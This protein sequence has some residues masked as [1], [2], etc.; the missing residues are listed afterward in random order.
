MVDT[1][2]R[3]TFVAATAEMDHAHAVKAIENLVGHEIS[4]GAAR[5]LIQ[6][7]NTRGMLGG[8]S[9]SGRLRTGSLLLPSVPVDVVV[10]PWSAVR[11][12]IGIG[13]L[14][15]YGRPRLAP[16]TE[17]LPGRVAARGSPDRGDHRDSCR[18]DAGPAGRGLEVFS[19][20]LPGVDTQFADRL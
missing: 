19:P 16:A 8:V 10:S 20:T 6:G 9:F 17:L 18:G 5:L 11:T 3:S 1:Q 13:P 2:I 14:G 12:E 15:H 4:A 7:R